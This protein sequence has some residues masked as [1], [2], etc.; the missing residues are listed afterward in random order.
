MQVAIIAFNRPRYFERVLEALTTAEGSENWA[1][2][3]YVDSPEHAVKPQS[4]ESVLANREVV[5][6][7]ERYS[8]EHRFRD[9]EFRVASRNLGVWENKRSCV[10]AAFERSDEVLV[11][12]DDIVVCRDALKFCEWAKSTGLLDASKVFQVS[13]FSYYFPQGLAVQQIREELA[14]RGL[15]RCVYTRHWATPWGWF[16]NRRAWS[17]IADEW[18][19]WDQ[20][21]GHRVRDLGM[22]EVAPLVSHCNNI[23]VVGVNRTGQ[24]SVDIQLRAITSDHLPPSENG[25]APY[26]GV[27]LEELIDSLNADGQLAFGHAGDVHRV[28]RHW[29]AADDGAV[30][31]WQR[32]PTRQIPSAPTM[33][34]SGLGRFR[35]ALGSAQVYVEFGIGWTTALAIAS[36]VRRIVSVDSDRSLVA[37]ALRDLGQE[38]SGR[39][40]VVHADIGIT[41]EFGYPNDRSAVAQWPQYALGVWG[42]SA[43]REASPD[44]VLISGRFRVACF[45]AAVLAMEPGSIVLFEDYVERP[46]YHVVEGLFSPSRCYGKLAEFVVP[47]TVSRQKALGILANWVTDAR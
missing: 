16:L 14:R 42:H 4:E 37:A 35:E 10:A 45:C 20:W 40:H 43:L 3:V 41:K 15:E 25:W 21:V 28:F 39:F 9:F 5:A 6:I 33:D 30:D 24:G 8:K 22:V 19:G 11:I 31:G 13:L 47:E 32:A 46:Y 26:M 29:E 23:G 12:E 17:L 18:N 36:S 44:L 27:Q 2:L 38:Q 34:E 7:C 1:V